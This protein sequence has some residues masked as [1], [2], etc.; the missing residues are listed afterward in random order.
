M[1]E[2]KDSVHPAIIYYDEDYITNDFLYVS[3]L[4]TEEVDRLLGT[5]DFQALGSRLLSRKPKHSVRQ[6]YFEDFGF[7][8][9]HSS[10]R[11]EQPLGIAKPA[12]K[13]GTMDKNIS[14][15]LVTC[16]DILR[17]LCST[18]F[19]FPEERLQEFASQLGEGNIIEAM[20]IAI[21]D[22]DNLCGVH[23]DGKNDAN[24]P[25]VPV[26]SEYIWLY[27]KRYRVSIIMYSQKSIGD[28][29]RRK[30]TTYGPAISFVLD[31]FY[32]IPASR[33]S[34]LPS[35]FP[36]RDSPSIDCQG[37]PCFD[38]P[39]HMNPFFFVSP[40]IHFG[41]ML[42]LHHSLDYAELVSVFRA[43][44]AMPYTTYY[45]CSGV[46]LLLQQR[47]LPVRGLLLGRLLLVL[48]RKL[49]EQHQASKTKIPGLRFATYRKLVVPGK[50]KWISSTTELVRLCLDASFRRDPPG[51]KKDKAWFYEK[52]RK[53]IG[54]EI[55]DAGNLISN[56]LMSIFGIVGLVPLWFSDQITVDAGSKAMKFLVAQKG[57]APGRPAAQRFLETLTSALERQYGIESTIRYGENLSC[58]SFR[59]ASSE[60]SDNRFSDLC[61]SEQCVFDVCHGK[62]EVHRSGCPKVVVDGPLIDRW[63]LDGNFWPLQQLL[64]QFGSLERD[65]FRIPRTLGE[66]REKRLVLEWT[67]TIFPNPYIVRDR[68]TAET[69][70]KDVLLL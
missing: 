69:I 20:R 45:F 31:T 51:N 46:T 43:W 21:T 66:Q 41:T 53:A 1:Q 32:N 36:N 8:S 58:K 28:F 4:H 52:T 27:G 50:E 64:L 48:M 29:L 67:R 11:K 23:E 60:G 55:P 59:L 37:V 44:A 25:A 18:F 22:E 56:H 65:S 12:L 68:H 39:C 14:E 9:G 7:C 2:V 6:S 47:Q 24:F 70:V 17:A 19:A 5:I 63:A 30:N 57:L 42:S 15:L 35:S 62:V 38:L 26:F 34:I 16:S 3:S 13:P 49:R 10:S 40:V 33:R 54:N 61:F